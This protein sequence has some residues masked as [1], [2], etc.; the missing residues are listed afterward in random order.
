MPVDEAEQRHG[1]AFRLT[2]RLFAGDKYLL[3][4]H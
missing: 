2:A 3:T 4:G 1:P